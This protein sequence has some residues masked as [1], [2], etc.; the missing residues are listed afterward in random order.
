[1]IK[2]IE[3]EIT[4]ECKTFEERCL[5]MI[6]SAGKMILL[7]KLLPKLK[8][9]NKKVLIFSQFIMVLTLLERYLTYRNYK[10]EKIVGSVKSKER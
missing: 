9:E 10:Y 1:M 7:D 5:K 2:E 3:Y 6:E 4:K 8:S